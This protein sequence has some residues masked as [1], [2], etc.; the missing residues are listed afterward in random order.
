MHS[1]LSQPHFEG[2]VRLPLTLPK[3]GLWSPL[4]LPKI[5]RS[6]AGVKTPCLEVFFIPLEKVL[7]F[8]CRKWPRMSH[9]D[10]CSTSYGGKKGRESDWQFDSWPLKVGNRPDPGACRQ[11]AAH[12]WRALNESYKFA[13]DLILIRGLSKKLW[14][15]KVLG[16]QIGTV[17]GLSLGSP[18]TNIHLGVVPMEWHK[19]YY[20][21]EGG[22]FPR[23]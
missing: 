2:S 5:Q 15:A 7:K 22:G 18:G 4:G 21:G 10:I 3:M 16:V 19:V 11:S 9:L 8:R 1:K 23:I 13:S 20:M 17:S 6:I 12:R 14:A